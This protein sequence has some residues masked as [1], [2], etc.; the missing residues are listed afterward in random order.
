MMMLRKDAAGDPAGKT[1]GLK[2]GKTE[3]ENRSGMNASGTHGGREEVAAIKP[4]N[5]LNPNL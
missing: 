1:E 5:A 3:Q 2:G 4:I